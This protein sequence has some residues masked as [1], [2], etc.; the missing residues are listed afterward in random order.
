V[1]SINPLATGLFATDSASQLPPGFKQNDAYSH[2]EI[3]AAHCLAGHGD[4]QQYI[5]GMTNMIG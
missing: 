5:A 3:Q 4:L 2:R 1:L